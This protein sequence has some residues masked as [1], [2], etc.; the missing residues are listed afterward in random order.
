[1]QQIKRIKLTQVELTARLILAVVVLAIIPLAIWVYFGAS[2][3]AS[4]LLAWLAAP[5]VPS[6]VDDSWMPISHALH[7]LDTHPAATGLYQETYFQSDSQFIY[8]VPSLIIFK[9]A[10]ALGVNWDSPS[11]L[12][13]LSWFFVPAIIFA[14]AFMLRAL[15][16]SLGL[17]SR[18]APS[19]FEFAL[20]LIFAALAVLF[21]YPIMRALS[22]GQIQTWLTFALILSIFLW[23]QER[24]T[25]AGILLGLV[26]VVK[27][28]IGIVAVWGLLRREWHFALGMIGTGATL[29]LASVLIF[30]WQVHSEYLQLLI[31]LSTRGES[32]H[33]SHSVESM[34]LR[35]THNGN[36]LDWDGSHTQVQYVPWI[37][38]TA[39]TSS[40]LILGSAL[41]SRKART[42]HCA[43]IDYCIILLA[44][45]VASPVAYEHHYGVLSMIF[46]CAAV[47]WCGYAPAWRVTGI[48][49]A[50]SY[51]LCA[52]LIPATDRLANS[53]WNVLQSYLLW[54][55]LLTLVLLHR[56][57]SV[58]RDAESSPFEA[59]RGAEALSGVIP[60]AKSLDRSSASSPRR[61]GPRYRCAISIASAAGIPG[62]PLSRE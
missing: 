34:L 17:R 61:R 52:N 3:V 10:R 39:M 51:A 45:V 55:A 5:F 46:L 47:L 26:S 42:K 48:S 1:M 7:Y 22:L 19:Y 8:S 21:F 2:D 16:T 41:F 14:E 11:S 4:G 13:L 36:N 60:A 40:L 15:S 18:G 24:K 6:E 9:V 37:H 31:F 50:V 44:A 29:G 23:F 27:P 58:V 56:L 25:A 43:L 33:Y 49:L 54:A 57:K 12:N 35:L 32:F 62:F 20:D 30:G 53:H 28:H 59:H 38:Y